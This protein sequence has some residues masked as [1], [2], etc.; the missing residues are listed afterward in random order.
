GEIGRILSRINKYWTVFEPES[1][2]RRAQDGNE[3]LTGPTD[4]PE[5]P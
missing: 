5:E 3:S 1:P 4:S 2:V